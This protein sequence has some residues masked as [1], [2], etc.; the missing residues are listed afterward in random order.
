MATLDFIC[1]G[2]PE[3][4][5]KVILPPIIVFILVVFI[6]EPEW[7][8]TM[9]GFTV[10]MMIVSLIVHAQIRTGSSVT[11]NTDTQRNMKWLF[12]VIAIG[13][14]GTIIVF[15]KMN[16]PGWLSNIAVVVLLL[17]A[18]LSFYESAFAHCVKKQLD[19]SLLG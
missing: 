10:A 19:Y 16:K 17:L 1:V 7:G 12:Y 4:I 9:L 3:S 18:G 2:D 13:L 8:W 14:L 6:D 11:P 5:V 15:A